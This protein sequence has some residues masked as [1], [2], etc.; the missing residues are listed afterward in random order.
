M[1]KYNIIYAD[2]PWD[3]GGSG[4]PS[5]SRRHAYPLMT[6]EAICALPV[7]DIAHDN[8]LLFLW[9]VMSRLPDAFRVIDAWGFSYVSNGFSWVKLYPKSRT[10]VLGMG[11][12]TRQNV[13]LCLI[14]K[15]GRPI[16]RDT[17]VSS[18]VV[19][20]RR[21]HSQKPDIVRDLIVR[22][23]GDVPRIELFARTRTPGWDIWG[24]ELANDCELNPAPHASSNEGG[25]P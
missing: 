2:P 21:R 25:A 3:Y 1:R 19:A 12:W 18:L 11:Y 13:E 4:F 10:P 8:A 24:N 15:R 17:R 6:T 23:C 20:P 9:A 22:I 14:A 7:R 5:L 16:R